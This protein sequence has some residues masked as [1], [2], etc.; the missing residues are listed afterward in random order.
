MANIFND[1]D[2][3]NLALEGT[4]SNY[5]NVK[6]DKDF[7]A[8]CEMTEAHYS[9]NKQQEMQAPKHQEQPGREEY[10]TRE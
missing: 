8:E 4:I 10:N 5:R 2:S 9:P 3:L 1:L 6:E 7:K